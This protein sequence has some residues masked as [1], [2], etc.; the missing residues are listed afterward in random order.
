MPV[1]L[2]SQISTTEAQGTSGAVASS[3]YVYEPPQQVAVFRQD[4]RVERTRAVCS[5]RTRVRSGPSRDPGL[6]KVK[7]AEGR[8]VSLDGKVYLGARSSLS[9]RSTRRR[10]SRGSGWGYVE[11]VQPKRK[12]KK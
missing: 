1:F 2:S 7:V 5:T 10:P 9:R 11:E 4:T 8:S 12:A 6:M 3:A